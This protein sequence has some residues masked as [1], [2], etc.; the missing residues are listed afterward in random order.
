MVYNMLRNN[1]VEKINSNIFKDH[2]QTRT[3]SLSICT[4]SESTHF[5][6][7]FD[8]SYIMVRVLQA[9]KPFNTTWMKTQK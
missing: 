8:V 2:V 1:E 3:P 7:S 5:Y 4:Y 6:E 9:K